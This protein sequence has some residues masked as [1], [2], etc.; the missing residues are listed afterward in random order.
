[1]FMEKIYTVGQIGKMYKVPLSKVYA[2]VRLIRKNN[3]WIGRGMG[4]VEIPDD[5][6]HRYGIPE[7]LVNIFPNI[8]IKKQS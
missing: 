5:P 6:Y 7:S 4:I 1:M 2:W 3:K 8:P